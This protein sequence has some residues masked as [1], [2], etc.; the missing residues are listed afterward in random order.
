MRLL[1]AASIGFMLLIGNVDVAARYIFNSPLDW[2]LPSV[3]L[4]L[5]MTI[6]CGLPI[7]S[8]DDEHITVGLLDRWVT[9]LAKKIQAITVNVL[10]LAALLFM[11]ER[12]FTYGTISLEDQTQHM[13]IDLSIWP[14]AYIF[15]L[16]ALISAFFVTRNIFR[17]FRNTSRTGER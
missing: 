13:M 11:S 17:G 9:G 14:Y 16:M 6:F 1:V 7:I 10:S 5:G 12:M 4:L 3:G 15:S 8:R 2:A